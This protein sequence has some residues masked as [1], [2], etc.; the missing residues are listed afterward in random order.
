[1]IF[2]LAAA[3]GVTALV[4]G[5]AVG[6]TWGRTVALLLLGLALGLAL[7]AAA[8]LTATPADQ[9]HD[10]SDCYAYLGRWWE[11]GFAVFVI[12]LALIA[13]ALGALVG[14]GIRA[15]SRRARLSA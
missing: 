3:A 2:L 4:L 14:S 9:R 11:P 10:C 8:Y 6:G 1:M 12:V 7:L 5:V 15:S 13:W